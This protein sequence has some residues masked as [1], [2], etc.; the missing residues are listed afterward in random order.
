MDNFLDRYHLPKLNQ[1]QVN[2]LHSTITFKEIEE[3]IKSLPTKEK[4]KARWFLCRTLSGIQIRAI[5]NTP[6]TTPQNRNRSN[7]V[8]LIL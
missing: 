1:D 4:L 7:I 6:Q 5:T 2:Y 3:V 8:K